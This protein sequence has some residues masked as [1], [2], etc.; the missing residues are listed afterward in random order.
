MGLVRVR[1]LGAT[2]RIG[3]V[4]TSLVRLARIGVGR[5]L[6]EATLTRSRQ[7]ET[8]FTRRPHAGADTIDTLNMAAAYAG[9]AFGGG[10]LRR[11]Y[12]RCVYRFPKL[13]GT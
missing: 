5:G 6:S 9:P 8:V 7:L 2:E 1:L 12:W 13:R 10:P 4:V 3:Y 11:R